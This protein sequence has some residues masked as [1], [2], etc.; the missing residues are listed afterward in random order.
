MTPDYNA[1]PISLLLHTME[2]ACKRI[3]SAI[4][5]EEKIAIFSDYDCDGI[6]GAVV[7]FDFLPPF[8]TSISKTTFT[9]ATKALGW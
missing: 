4:E 3:E 9:P 1:Q 2:E 8:R 5:H 6:P 7:L